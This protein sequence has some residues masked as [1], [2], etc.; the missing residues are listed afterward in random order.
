LNKLLKKIKVKNMKLTAYLWN[1][2]INYGWD[3]KQGELSFY[4]RN[5]VL[6]RRKSNGGLFK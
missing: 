1:E 5:K 3:G 6:N 4:L 2:I